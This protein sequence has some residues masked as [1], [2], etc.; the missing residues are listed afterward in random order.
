MNLK[1]KEE[2]MKAEY[3]K[4][5][6]DVENK[7]RKGIESFDLFFSYSKNLNFFRAERFRKKNEP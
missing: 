1:K 4:F 5:K 7:Y 3:Q 6:N 2:S